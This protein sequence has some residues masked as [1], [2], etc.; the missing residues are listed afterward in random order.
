M[1]SFS[2]QHG[3][4]EHEQ[5]VPGRAYDTN[6]PVTCAACINRLTQVCDRWQ[7]VLSKRH[8]LPDSFWNGYKRS[9]EL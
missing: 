9:F 5:S 2:D 7:A 1:F 4:H 6:K 8:N 3:V